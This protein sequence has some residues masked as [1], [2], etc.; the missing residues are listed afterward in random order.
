MK[1]RD[2][3]FSA[4][5]CIF[6]CGPGALWAAQEKL[7]LDLPSWFT[8]E[9]AQ[10]LSGGISKANVKQNLTVEGFESEQLQ[11]ALENK[12]GNHIPLKAAAILENAKLQ[13]NVIALS[14][15]AFDWECYPTYFGS[16]Q[17]YIPAQNALT[18]IAVKNDPSFDEGLCS[19]ADELVRL[20]QS[21]PD[22]DFEMYIVGSNDGISP[23]NPTYSLV[24]NA[25]TFDKVTSRITEYINEYSVP[26]LHCS[27]TAECDNRSYYDSFYRCDRHWCINGTLEAYHVIVSE[28]DLLSIDFGSISPIE[29]QSFC[30]DVARPG[31]AYLA[32]PVQDINYDFSNL[33]ARNKTGSIQNL[34]EHPDYER[35]SKINRLFNFYG[36]YYDMNY[37]ATITG[38]KGD[39]STLLV[40]DSFGRSLTRLIAES[41]DTTFRSD[42]LF[43]EK[44]TSKN[45]YS[46]ISQNNVEA[47]IFVAKPG[48][49]VSFL[50]RNPNYFYYTSE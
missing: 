2:V 42:A 48:N 37:D 43:G 14:N 27:Y 46:F 17:V 4:L 18:G 3:L 35:A 44:R 32:E 7:H 47:V 38:G 13:R 15:I 22:V 12:I 30:G 10:Y 29:G 26:N 5:L 11:E 9:D 34:S 24:S 21:F 6:L 23:C 28:L 8:A 19:F 20:A 25:R 45:A 40:S 50:E 1:I 16:E 36:L 49:Y 31:R 39:K 41:S 33:S